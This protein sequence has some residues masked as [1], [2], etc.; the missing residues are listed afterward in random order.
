MPISF[1]SVPSTARVP[2]FYAEFDDSRAQQGPS[3]LAYKVLMLGQK[4]GAGSATAEVPVLVSSKSNATALFGAGSMLERMCHKFFIQ[5]QVNELWAIPSDDASGTPAAGSIT[6]TSASTGAGTY[7]LYI[8]GRLVG[9]NGIAIASGLTTAQLATAVAAAIQADTSLPVTAVADGG[10]PTVVDITAKNDGTVGNDI[11]IRLN[12]YPNDEA[13][14]AGVAQTIVQMT[15]GATDPSLAN[16]VSAMGETQYHVIVCPWTIGGMYQT[17]EDELDDRWG[18]IRQ[19]EGVLVSFGSDSLANLTTLGNARNSK[20][21]VIPGLDGSP[22]P[23][24]EWAAAVAG[25]V[26]RYGQQ[27]PAR[28]FQTLEVKGVLAPA[29][30]D[31]FLW[32]ERNVLLTDGISDISFDQNG[33]ARISR[34]ATTWQT[35][36]LSNPSISYLNLNTVLTL[37]YLRFDLKV[38]FESKYNRH[39]LADDGTLFG[40][41]QAI[42]TPKIAKA[43]VIV[44][45]RQWELLGLVEGV[46]QF[47]EDLIVERNILNPDRLDMLL[48]PDLVNQLRILGVKFSF[49]L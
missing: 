29:L 43:E 27:D 49:L 45:F 16:V 21:T 13:L 17:L 7:F 19:I 24:D 22:T 20:H 39:K 26:A 41:G 32:S 9:G 31:R 4:I 8:G 5:T 46:D 42:I 48:S 2:L 1:N 18:P 37:A 6:F 35:D 11:D 44:K 47:K 28:P 23:K 15:S 12:Y 10:T 36:A 14:P 3:V 40:P 30:A 34:L 33:T 25:I 38:Y